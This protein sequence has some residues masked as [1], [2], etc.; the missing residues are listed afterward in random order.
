[1]R[2]NIVHA[3][4]RISEAFGTDGIDHDGFTAAVEIVA[5][6]HEVTWLNVH[7][8]NDDAD[9]QSAKIADAD[10]VLVRSDWN[11]YPA[12]ATDRALW[13]RPDVPVGLLIAGSTLPPAP[14]Q[15]RRF[16]VIF[17]ETPWYEQFTGPHPFAVQA[18]GVDTRVMRVT[19]RGPRDYD[20]L[21]VGRLAA[22]KRPERLME[23]SGRRLAIGDL[24]SAKPDLVAALKNGGIELSSYQS[25]EGLA[26][27]YNHA[28]R[29]LVPCI[30]QGGGERAVLEGRACGCE[31]E[32]ADDNP[33]LASLLTS[34]IWTHEDYATTL[35]NALGDIERGR[36]I[37]AN[38]KLAGQRARR[39]AVLKDKLRRLPSTIVIRARNA[40]R[41]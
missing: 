15:M 6:Q 30:L 21:M 36:V 28:R 3:V 10:F 37:D 39:N 40:V 8:Y 17:Y 4:P 29:V 26:D 12:Q 1:M 27:L 32:I 5:Q 23:K 7:P 24:S 9:D 18:F 41:R 31:I 20:W 16:D 19:N 2:I 11:W 33:K 35:L 25:H 22:F 34:P 13:K 14:I 38:T